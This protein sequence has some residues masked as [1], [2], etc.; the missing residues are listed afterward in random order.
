MKFES[1]KQAIL[2]TEIQPLEQFLSDEFLDGIRYGDHYRWRRLISEFPEIQASEFSFDD[3]IRIGSS[4]D[5]DQD[6][7]ALLEKQ[8]KEFIPWRKGPFELFGIQIDSEWRS[9]LKWQRLKDDISPLAGRRV[10]DVG[11]GNGY[12]S[13]RMH[14]DGA[15]LVIGLEP[16]IP[17]YG[18][19]CAIK[20]YVPEIPVYVIPITMEQMPE[21]LEGFDT[22]FSM[23]VL[24]HRRSPLDHLLQLFG[25]LKPGG[26]L[27]LETI[28]VAGPQGYAL[29]PKGRYSR[30]NNVWFIPSIESILQW[31]DRIGFCNAR[32]IDKSLTTADEQ[33]QTEWMPFDSLQGALQEE[34]SSLTIEGYPA[35]ERVIIACNKPT[36]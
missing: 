33:R 9:Q 1:L 14:G 5:S 35:P 22:V 15:D 27:V 18:Q 11:S 30:M 3:S 6:R 16:H 8:L 17:Y 23:G 25:Q 10:L 2:G 19:F 28:Y 26:E 32:V 24:Y 31:L 4:Q 7:R 29:L 21:G 34:D 20:R 12:S 36:S 13:F